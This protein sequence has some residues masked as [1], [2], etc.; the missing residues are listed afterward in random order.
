MSSAWYKKS[1]AQ[2]QNQWSKTAGLFFAPL[3]Q[4]LFS[5]LDEHLKQLK[6]DVLEIGIGAGQNFDDYPQGMSLIAVD[7]NP[8]VE[9]LLKENLAKA[10]GRVQMKTFIV[11]SSED[12]S[13]SEGKVG[14]EDNSVAAVV[15]TKLLCSLTEEQIAKTVQEVKRVLMPVSIV[16]VLLLANIQHNGGRFFFMEHVLGK[17]WTLRYILQQLV[18]KSHLWPT[19]FNGCRCDHETLPFIQRGGFKLVKAEKRYLKV[20]PELH[21][22]SKKISVDWSSRLLAYLVHSVL[23]GFAEKER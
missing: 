17:P 19:L 14:V 11:A 16:I 6:G 15:C 10:G 12:M 5:D 23:L 1:F 13:G 4:K 8:H 20:T 3:K 7:Y 18:S 22:G 21:V 9:K 2:R